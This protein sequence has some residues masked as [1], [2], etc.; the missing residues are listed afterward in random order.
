[1]HH[2][3]Q[4]RRGRQQLGHQPDPVRLGIGYFAPDLDARAASRIGQV[5]LDGPGVRAVLL[6]GAYQLT[7][8]RPHPLLLVLPDVVHLPARPTRAPLHSVVELLSIELDRAEPGR[9]GVVPALVDAMLLYILR[10]WIDERADEPGGW[11]GALTDPG[12]RAALESIHADPARAWTIKSLAATA[13]LSRSAFAQ[14]FAE[15]VGG[16]P[17][18]YVTWWRMTLAGRLLHDTDSPLAVLAHR[19]GY[20]SEFGFAKAFKREFGVAPGRYR[21]SLRIR[22]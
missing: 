19:V 6:C 4:L 10:A 22:S 2:P 15:H 8:A 14:R 3:A 11:A 12:V 1:V 18:R 9:D 20:T 17:M 16:P 7:R 13:G 5:R 21:T